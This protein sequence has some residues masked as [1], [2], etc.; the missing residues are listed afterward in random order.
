MLG[1]IYPPLGTTDFAPYIAKLAPY[2]GK[3]DRA[4]AFFTG[5]DA[6]RF[7]NQYDEYGLK[8]K[9]KLLPRNQVYVCFCSSACD[10]SIDM[11]YEMA[12]MGFTK[13]YIF[14]GGWDEWKK[15]GYPLVGE[16]A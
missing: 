12:H 8:D 4:W 14:H 9:L 3:A 5:G 7:V 10:V 11:A 2:V 16:R 15:A 1:E 6:I 13:M